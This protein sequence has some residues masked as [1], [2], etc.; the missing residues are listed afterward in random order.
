MA[1]TRSTE[2]KTQNRP[3]S[4]APANGAK[5]PFSWQNLT[6]EDAPAVHTSRASQL[7]GTPFVAWLRE[8]RDGNTAKTLRVGSADR[9]KAA[10]HM[11]RLAAKE[12]GCGVKFGK[13]SDD[14]VHYQ[15]KAKRDYTPPTKGTCGA[16]GKTIVTRKAD[17]MLSNHGPRDKRCAGSGK[18]PK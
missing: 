1:Q 13:T 12:L 15:A 7:D 6:V 4:A 9:K 16:C 18:A 2:T 10:V 14:T 5:E 11:L 3:G 8:S 17:G